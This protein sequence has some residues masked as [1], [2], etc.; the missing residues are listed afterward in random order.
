MYY[1]DVWTLDSGVQTAW[2]RTTFIAASSRKPT[3][4]TLMRIIMTS[5][6]GDKN[7]SN[8]ERCVTFAGHHT[9]PMTFPK[10]QPAPHSD[11]GGE[12][13]SSEMPGEVVPSS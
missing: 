3:K 7:S 8:I 10:D 2:I 9:F 4:S 5:G 13:P 6:N 11:G 12:Q 1:A